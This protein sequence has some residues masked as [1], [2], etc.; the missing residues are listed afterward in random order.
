MDILFYNRIKITFRLAKRCPAMT[1]GHGLRPPT[2]TNGI[3]Q[4]LNLEFRLSRDI[5]MSGEKFSNADLAR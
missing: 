3:S 2:P 1:R 4:I 5:E